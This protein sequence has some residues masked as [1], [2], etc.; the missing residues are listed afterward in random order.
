MVVHGEPQNSDFLNTRGSLLGS[1]SSAVRHGPP[2]NMI[3]IDVPSAL[4]RK[5][6]HWPAGRMDG[7]S[8]LTASAGFP[9]LHEPSTEIKQYE[10]QGKPTSRILAA[11]FSFGK[12]KSTM[13]SA[14]P[15]FRSV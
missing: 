9:I 2:F 15:Y 10:A 1:P 11:P 5:R 13:N 14:L 4:A 8:N 3:E 7:S 6:F 12:R